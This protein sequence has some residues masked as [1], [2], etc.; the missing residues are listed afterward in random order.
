MDF[1]IQPC[2][3]QSYSSVFTFSQSQPLSQKL[4]CEALLPLFEKPRCPRWHPSPLPDIKTLSMLTPS[5]CTWPSTFCSCC[6]LCSG[7]IVP[8]LTAHLSALTFQDSAEVHFFQEAFQI[9]LILGIFPLG[10]QI[11]SWV[12][13]GLFFWHVVRLAFSLH[14]SESWES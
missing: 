5:P 2:F 11:V 1:D 4:I 7:M 6:S 3:P 14:G 12:L 10:A 8:L 9:I 13:F